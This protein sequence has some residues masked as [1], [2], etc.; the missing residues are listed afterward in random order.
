GDYIKKGPFPQDPTSVQAQ[1]DYRDPSTGR[2]SLRIVARHADR[3]H[4]EEGGSPATINSP[5]VQNGRLETSALRVSLLAVDSSGL[6]ETGQAIE[7]LNT[8]EVK[9][10]VQYRSGAHQV[11]LKALP[12]GTIRYSLD[13]SDPRNGAIYDGEFAVPA[14]IRLV[15]TVAE[16]A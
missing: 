8:I 6:H 12:Q 11:T 10:D 3:V 2:C 15:L 9:Y 5:V 14:G 7:W 16:Q 13:G 4:Y 1:L